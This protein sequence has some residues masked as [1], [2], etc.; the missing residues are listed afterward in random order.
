MGQQQNAQNAQL[1]TDSMSYSLQPVRRPI[2][3]LRLRTKGG[4]D[5]IPSS[6]FINCREKLCYPL[7]QVFAVSF[8]HE[9]IPPVWPSAFIIPLSKKGIKAD[10]SNYRPMALTCTMCKLMESIIKDQLLELLISKKLIS[11]Y[12]HDFIKQHSKQTNSL[13]CMQDWLPSWNSHLSTDVYIDFSRAFDSIVV[14]KLLFNQ[15]CY[16]IS[17]L[18]LMDQLV[19]CMVEL[20]V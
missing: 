1:Q 11:K 15:N 18:L 7:S 3:K 17:G 14:S 5:D 12:Q 6:S 9:I 4:P 8:E 2:K 20:S 19:F 16:D 10:A 13:Q